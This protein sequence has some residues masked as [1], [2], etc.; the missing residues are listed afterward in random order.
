MTEAEREHWQA[1]IRQIADRMHL[2][3]WRVELRQRP[4]E[5]KDAAAEVL[6]TYGRKLAYIY[7]AQ[8][9]AD[10]EAEK[11]RHFVVHELVH[12]HLQTVR[13]MVEQDMKGVLG[14]QAH[15]VLLWPFKRALEYGVDGLA[16][17][18][19]PLMPLPGDVVSEL[20]QGQAA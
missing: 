9:W 1:Y 10:I 6:C 8:D 12:L 13:D 18:I 15:E 5:N 3:D 20:K 19:A 11:Q 16:D 14:N 17:A 4:P 2:K 7:F